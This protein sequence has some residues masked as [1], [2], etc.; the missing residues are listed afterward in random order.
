MSVVATRLVLD[1]IE[2]D[3]CPLCRSDLFSSDLFPVSA[4]NKAS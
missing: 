2:I 1:L 3:F 4:K